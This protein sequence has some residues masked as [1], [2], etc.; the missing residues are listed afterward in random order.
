MTILVN[1]IHFIDYL[2]LKGGRD[3]LLSFFSF[4]RSMRKSDEGKCSKDCIFKGLKVIRD[5]IFWEFMKLAFL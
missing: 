1:S 5:I 2:M 3:R 4:M